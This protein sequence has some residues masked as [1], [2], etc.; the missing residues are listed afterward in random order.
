MKKLLSCSAISFANE[1]ESL[2]VVNCQA[3]Q[4]MYQFFKLVF[5]LQTTGL[6]GGQISTI[7]LRTLQRP[8]ETPGL[9]AFPH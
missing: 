9:S 7:A 4:Y 2:T 5:Q 8:Y 1:K 3:T 6:R